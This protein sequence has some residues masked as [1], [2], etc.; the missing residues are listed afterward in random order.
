M[1]PRIKAASSLAGTRLRPL[2]LAAP[3]CTLGRACAAAAP[4]GRKARTS[5][6]R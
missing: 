5:W 4:R 2:C 1:E 3:F 6:R